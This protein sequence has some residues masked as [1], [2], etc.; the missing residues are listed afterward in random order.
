MCIHSQGRVKILQTAQ[1]P[2]VVRYMHQS[3]ATLHTKVYP[4]P[5]CN[6]L[7]VGS[8]THGKLSPPI[9]VLTIHTVKPDQTEKQHHH[10]AMLNISNLFRCSSQQ[11]CQ[12][13]LCSAYHV[14]DIYSGTASGEPGLSSCQIYSLAHS[15]LAFQQRGRESLSCAIVDPST[16]LSVVRLLYMTS[17]Q[18]VHNS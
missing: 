15:R 4:Q 6:S 13:D 7:R 8:S 17:T 12:V 9:R 18:S 10:R 3:F 2:E 16:L 11:S 5:C 14:H 1:S